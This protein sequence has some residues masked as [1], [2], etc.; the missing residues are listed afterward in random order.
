MSAVVEI[1]LKTIS[2][3]PL[4]LF[5]P[6]TKE[7]RV[8]HKAQISPL[9]ALAIRPQTQTIH[10]PDIAV[11]NDI[12]ETPLELCSGD[13]SNNAGPKVSQHTAGSD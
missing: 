9:I 4:Q 2:F 8:S 1:A 6:H 7:T 11:G 5:L 3:Y 13:Q 12:I 10:Q